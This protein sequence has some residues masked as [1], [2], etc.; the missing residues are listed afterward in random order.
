MVESGVQLCERRHEGTAQNAGDH[1]RRM[2]QRILRQFGDA[3]RNMSLRLRLTV[4]YGLVVALVVA[5]LGATLYVTMATRLSREMD[6]RLRVRADEVQYALWPGPDHPTAEDL[7]P[8]KLD[9]SPLADLDAPTLHVQVLDT[10]GAVLKLSDNLQGHPLPVGREHLTAA[11]LGRAT[12]SDA[13]EAGRPLRVLSVPILV[14]N[15]VT[16]VLQISQSRE[17]LHQTLDDLR[18][19]LIIIGSV[20]VL[21][22][23]AIGWLLSTAGL[24]PLRTISRQA[25]DIATSKDFRRRL[26]VAHARGEISELAQTI[27]A[28]LAKVEET[29]QAHR[30]FLADTSHEL[31]NP[32]LAIRTNAA[33][34]NR[35]QADEREE[36]VHELQQQVERMSRLISDLLLLAQVERGLVLEQRPVDLLDVVERAV[37]EAR[38]RLVGQRLRV[39]HEESLQMLGDAQ[40]LLQILANLLDNAIKHTPPEGL[41][42]VRTRTAGEGVEIRVEDSGEGI[43]PEHLP[44]IFDRAFRVNATHGRGPNASYGLGLAI[45][46]YLTEAHGGSVTVHSELGLGST[47]IVWFP[48]SPA[49]C[50]ELAASAPFQQP[51]VALQPR[52]AT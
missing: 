32:L 39:E 8:S 48:R 29:L 35:L 40:R 34:I 16:G 12:F 41:I 52:P 42:T 7:R 19:L 44:H 24:Q 21:L 33:L 38:P 36:C 22:S 37:Q 17:L 46:K 6:Q 14:K 43:S 31:R 5:V 23:G 28:L 51:A 3:S 11:L 49:S 2:P 10:S 30:D 18:R 45:V 47:F 13:I 4:A 1:R 50:P 15:T 26:H 25:V 27:D 20:A 9:L